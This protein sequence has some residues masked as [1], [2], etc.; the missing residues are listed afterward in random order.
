MDALIDQIEALL[1]QILTERPDPK[2]QTLCK[3]ILSLCKMLKNA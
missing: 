1:G 3:G 2:V